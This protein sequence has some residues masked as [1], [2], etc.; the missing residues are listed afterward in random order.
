MVLRSI[1]LRI[2]YGPE[3]TE[4]NNTLQSTAYITHISI[5]SN[6]GAKTRM[7]EEDRGRY[8]VQNMIGVKDDEFKKGQ[9]SFVTR[10]W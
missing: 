3:S 10:S 6:L 5:Q 2:R 4:L 8:L 9:I 7:L 1:F